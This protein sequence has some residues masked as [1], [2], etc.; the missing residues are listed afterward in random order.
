M[1]RPAKLVHL[2]ILLICAVGLA[3]PG[4]AGATVYLTKEKAIKQILPKSEK[5]TEERKALTPKQ[6]QAIEKALR[7]KIKEKAF[8]FYVGRTNDKIDGYAVIH[9]EIGKEL[10]ITFIIGIKPNGKI[11]EVAVME[12][13]ESRGGEVRHK[14]FLHQFENKDSD[15]PLSL[16]KDIKNITGATLS[17]RAAIVASRKVLAAWE[18]LYGGK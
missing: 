5:V 6:K 4:R 14:R 11:S 13:R 3:L 9:D 7:G 1:K 15:D 2:G 8:T 16:N 17:C 12:F 18:E 10:P